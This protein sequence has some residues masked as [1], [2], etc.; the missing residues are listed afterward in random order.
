MLRLH[1]HAL[2]RRAARRGYTMVALLALMTVIGIGLMAAE[3]AWSTLLRRDR[4]EEL[5]FRGEQYALAIMEFKAKTGAFPTDLKQLI[6]GKPR[7]IRQL[8]KDPMTPDGEWY[9]VRQGD[10]LL[11]LMATGGEQG[12][13]PGAG[14]GKAEKIE[15]PNKIFEDSTIGQLPGAVGGGMA[16]GPIVG[17]ASVSP[18]KGFRKYNERENYNQWLFLFDD[19]CGR[20]ALQAMLF[21]TGAGLGGAPTL[22]CQPK[23]PVG[24]APPGGVPGLP[25]QQPGLPGSQP[26]PP[27]TQPPAFGKK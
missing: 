16:T 26:L 25:G 21:M 19:I 27:G 11:Q 1:D 6:E 10:P 18:L 17:V 12:K 15:M 3:Q 8:F 9:L 4:E 14:V 13:A 20:R 2:N 24:I 23:W 7:Y 5:I 22:P